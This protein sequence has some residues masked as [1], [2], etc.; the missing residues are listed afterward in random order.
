MIEKN[1]FQSWHSYQLHPEVQDK[2]DSYKRLNPEY[3]YFLYNDKDIDNF[4]NMHFKGEIADCYNKLNIIVAKVDFW[5]YLVL[6][7]YGGIYLDIDSSIEISLDSLIQDND[8]AIITAEQ[9]PNIYVQWALIF[10]KGHPILKRTIELIVDN[11]KTNRYPNDILKMTGPGIYSQAIN[12]IYNEYY[13]TSLDHSIIYRDTNTTYHTINFSYR[14]YSID[15]NHYLL[16]K[17][18]LTHLLQYKNNRSWRDDER[19]KPLII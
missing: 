9:N 14:I 19:E 1:I 3:K 16:Y 2:I 12:E 17:H 13:N 18:H 15:Y 4:V 7:K 6:Y 11:I 10:K 8:E 5:R